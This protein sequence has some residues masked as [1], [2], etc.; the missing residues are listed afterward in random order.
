MLFA[1]SACAESSEDNLESEF[2]HVGA[3]VHAV[4]KLKVI[5][6]LSLYETDYAHADYEHGGISYDVSIFEIVEP[7]KYRGRQFP[8]LHDPSNE[9]ARVWTEVGRTYS[10]IIDK[11]IVEREGGFPGPELITI[12]KEIE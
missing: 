11:D 9:R 4:E 12:V 2:I 8:V 10:M 5:A 1:A 7:V 3:A 6:T